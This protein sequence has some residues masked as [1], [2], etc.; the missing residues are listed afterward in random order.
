MRVGRWGA[1]FGGRIFPCVIGRGGLRRD[2]RE[3][4]GATPVGRFGLT[5]VWWRADRLARPRTALARRPIGPRDGWSDDPRDPFY[6]RPVR[7][8]HGYSA[9]RMRRGDR[10]YDVVIAT[11][12]NAEGAPG[13]GSAIFVHL[14]KRPGARTAGCL[15]LRRRDLLW[16][17]AR[18]PRG[19]LVD[20]RPQ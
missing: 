17:L 6:N 19:G 8:P 14:R 13:A 12:H 20:I 18:W 15:G 4:D 3:G 16:L 9:E 10:L 5:Q 11:T 1:R 7:L 2:K